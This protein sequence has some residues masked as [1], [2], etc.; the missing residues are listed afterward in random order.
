MAS[1]PISEKY[2][3]APG[4]LP[5]PDAEMRAGVSHPDL[6]KWLMVGE[7]WAH[8]VA[9]AAPVPQPFYVDIGCGCG[10]TARF[11]KLDRGARYL[12]IDAAPHFVAWC[13][14]AFAS[15]EGFEFTHL[16]IVSPDCN[17]GGVLDPETVRLPC[18]DGVAD[19]IVCASLF[20]HLLEPVFHHYIREIERL[21]S[22]VGRAVISIHNEPADGRFSGTVPRIDISEE[23]FQQIVEESGLVIL[24]R[25]GFV[26]G[27]ILF[28]VG[29]P[30]DPGR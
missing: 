28:L 25:I 27:Q 24:E 23:Y 30:G 16:N 21:L 7:A 3:A 22:P 18:D 12:G 14:E 29:R 13:Q 10:K 26:F 2:A 1:D 20:T 6:G 4:T 11:L 8:I 17:P 19:M 15:V 9:H 5:I